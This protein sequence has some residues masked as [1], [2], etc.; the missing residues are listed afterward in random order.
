M[1]FNDPDIKFESMFTVPPRTIE[2]SNFENLNFYEG[3]W[4]LGKQEG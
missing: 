3:G 1:I 2:K 4:V